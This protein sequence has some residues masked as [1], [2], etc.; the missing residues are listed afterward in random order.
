ARE[1]HDL[2]TCLGPI[3]QHTRRMPTPLKNCKRWYPSP[4]R[5]YT[6]RTPTPLK[7]CKRW[8]PSPTRGY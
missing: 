4:T 3:D 2:S 5:G 6:R 1:A 8:Y 7:N